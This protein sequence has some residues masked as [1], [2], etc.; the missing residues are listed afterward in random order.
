MGHLSQRE[1]LAVAAQGQADLPGV[2]KMTLRQRRARIAAAHSAPQVLQTATR[3]GSTRPPEPLGGG[4]TTIGGNRR[5]A[6]RGFR[7]KVGAPAL[8]ATP[9]R[10]E[11]RRSRRAAGLLL[12][13]R[14]ER[15]QGQSVILRSSGAGPDGNDC[16]VQT[17]PDAVWC[18]G[19]C[20]EDVCL[21]TSS[22]RNEHRPQPRSG[23]PTSRARDEAVDD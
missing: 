20:G 3:I 1:K 9:A 10:R 13:P 12:I 4:A 23:P 8:C 11:L 19:G 17:L 2:G 14:R 7:P 6:T 5:A 22:A 21:P 15:S 16:R 18:R